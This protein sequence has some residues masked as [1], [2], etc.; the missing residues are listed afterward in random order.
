[1]YPW[2][3]DAPDCPRLNYSSCIGDTTPVGSYPTGASPYGALDM[4]GNVWEWVN[5]W[6]L[7]NYYDS[8]P[9]SN[10]PGPVSGTY[11]VL[12]GGSRITSWAGVRAASRHTYY[13]HGKTD[14]SFGFRCVVEPAD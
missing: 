8:S 9:Y 4:S 2:G 13:P 6:Y 3:D 1:V 11:K 14:N 10:P 5:D 7:S 12:R